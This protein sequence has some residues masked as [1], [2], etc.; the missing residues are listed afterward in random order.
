MK[1][2]GIPTAAFE[3]FTDVESALE[4]VAHCNIPVV[5]KADGLALGKGVIIAKSR[6]EAADAV[7]SMMR[8]KKFGDS[9]TTV[10]IEQFLSGPEVSVLA[11]TDGKTVKPMVSSITTSV[12]ATAIRDLIPEA[13]A[14]SRPI[15]FIPMKSPPSV[16][17][18]SFCRQ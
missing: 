12:R 17:K 11:F 18:K 2:Y 5:I 1:K 8:D 4:Y 10:V 7:N 14:Q 9:G 3:T 16:W 15:R 13:W 6:A